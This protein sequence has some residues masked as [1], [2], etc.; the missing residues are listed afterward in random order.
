MSFTQQV[1]PL[2]MRE[3]RVVSQRNA[4]TQ[5]SISER[6]LI[7]P[8]NKL[9]LVQANFYAARNRQIKENNRIL[10]D[11]DAV[12]TR[13]DSISQRASMALLNV[14]KELRLTNKL[15]SKPYQNVF[16]HGDMS[17]QEKENHTNNEAHK[18]AFSLKINLLQKKRKQRRLI[19]RRD[20]SKGDKKLFQQEAN[21]GRY[22]KT[23]T[24]KKI[25]EQ[26]REET[27]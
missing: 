27:P 26:M 13:C 10:Q 1:S 11:D 14:D 2:N 23:I 7:K 17:D 20:S 19:I 6:N 4:L 18:A 24:M 22:I 21:R 25:T 15:I 16:D 3:S 12:S 5:I 9:M 8:Q